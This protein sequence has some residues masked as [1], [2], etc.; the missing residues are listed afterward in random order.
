VVQQISR[1]FHL[2]KL[3][4]LLN[5]SCPLHPSPHSLLQSPF[6]FLFKIWLFYVSYIS[7][8]M[9]HL[10]FCEWLFHIILSPQVPS[11]WQYDRIFFFLKG[12]QEFSCGALDKDLT[13][14]LQWLG[15]PLW[16]GFDLWPSHFYKLRV[17]PPPKDTNCMEYW[18]PLYAY[19]TF[20]LSILLLT[21]T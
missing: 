1:I 8:I 15:S 5:N 12:K 10:S 17:C 19:T 21:D 6:Y 11:M 3:K 18:I 7:G 2:A 4:Y 14:S 20:S 16:H 13:L 9:K